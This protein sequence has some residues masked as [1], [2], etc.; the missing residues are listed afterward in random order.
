MKKLIE[1]NE[2]LD[3][4]LHHPS[5]LE[6]LQQKHQYFEVPDIDYA[7]TRQKSSLQVTTRYITIYT[8]SVKLLPKFYTLMMTLYHN[9][10]VC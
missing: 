5:L 2:N 9:P 8:F 10:S 3:T 1:I 6:N 7:I 4:P